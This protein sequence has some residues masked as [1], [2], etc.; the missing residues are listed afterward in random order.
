MSLSELMA[1]NS[2]SN[3]EGSLIEITC[4]GG[5]SG[6]LSPKS[7]NFSGR[8]ESIIVEVSATS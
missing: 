8:E 6:N 4:V 1:L 5:M 2:F 7:S 3:R